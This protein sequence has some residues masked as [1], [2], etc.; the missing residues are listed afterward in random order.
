MLKAASG[1]AAKIGTEAVTLLIE[2]YGATSIK[3]IPGDQR[4]AFLK[5]LKEIGG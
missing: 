5:D 3:E 2:G 1:A 4:A